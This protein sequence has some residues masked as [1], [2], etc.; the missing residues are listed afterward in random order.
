M[1]MQQQ[2]SICFPPPKE[3]HDSIYCALP[4]GPFLMLTGGGLPGHGA[5][6]GPMCVGPA[7]AIIRRLGAASASSPARLNPEKY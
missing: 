7:G 4:P 2:Q 5:A 3:K 1:N 6:H